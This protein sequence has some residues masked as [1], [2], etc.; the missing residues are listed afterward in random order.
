MEEVHKTP[1]G[2]GCATGMAV[3]EAEPPVLLSLAFSALAL[4][5]LGWS[6]MASP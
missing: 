2:P 5:V 4:L 1:C 3:L 6:G